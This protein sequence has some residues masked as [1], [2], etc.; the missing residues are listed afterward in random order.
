MHLIIEI[1][2]LYIINFKSKSEHRELKFLDS[3]SWLVHLV[4][5]FPVLLTLKDRFVPEAIVLPK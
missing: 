4:Q 2:R 1:N 3:S 5:P